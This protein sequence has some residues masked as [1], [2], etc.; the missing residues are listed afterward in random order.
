MLLLA[1]PFCYASGYTL[2]VAN[3]IIVT[4]VII[5]IALI[6]MGGYIIYNNG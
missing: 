1:S 5:V 4:L 2:T 3:N 6:A